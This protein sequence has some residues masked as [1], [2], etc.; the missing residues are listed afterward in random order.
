[1]KLFT[2]GM[3]PGSIGTYYYNLEL[4]RVASYANASYGVYRISE[5]S[6]LILFSSFGRG[7][8]LPPP[9]TADQV[10]E[11]INGDLKRRAFEG[12]L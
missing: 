12:L 1:M 8:Q 7:D 11:L 4:E 6:F 10:V 3:L 2:A 9:Q 5:G